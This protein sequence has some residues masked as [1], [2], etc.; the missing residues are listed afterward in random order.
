MPRSVGYVLLSFCV[1]QSERHCVLMKLFLSQHEMLYNKLCN[2]TS[3]TD[4]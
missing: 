2:D 4:R 1:A 3:R